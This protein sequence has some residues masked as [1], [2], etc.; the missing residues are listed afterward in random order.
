MSVTEFVT[1]YFALLGFEP[2][3]PFYLVV[4]PS[5][6]CCIAL[7]LLLY[8][9]NLRRNAP[10]GQMSSY[11]CLLGFVWFQL[12]MNVHKGENHWFPLSFDFLCLLLNERNLRLQVLSCSETCFI[13]K[14]SLEISHDLVITYNQMLIF[15]RLFS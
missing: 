1:E 4:L 10:K 14:D 12:R 2:M 8:C 3:P 13:F 9:Q 6:F 11:I 7:F 15:W 5:F